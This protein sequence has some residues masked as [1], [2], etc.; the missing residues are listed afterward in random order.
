MTTPLFIERYLTKP[1]QTESAQGLAFINQLIAHHL[2]HFSFCSAN[3]LLKRDLSLDTEAV[4]QR[5]IEQRTGGYCFE[6]NKLFHTLLSEL[7]FTTRPLLARVLLNGN[8]DNGRT[9][10]VTLLELNGVQYLVDVGF[11]VQTPRMAIPLETHNFEYLSQQ[12]RLKKAQTHFRLELWQDDHWQALYRFDLSE[13]T[14]M[15]CDIGHFYTSQNPAS[16][17]Y[18]NLVISNLSQTQRN[19]LKNL[20]WRQYDDEL[21]NERVVNIES[22]QQLHQLLRQTFQLDFDEQ[23][24]QQLFDHQVQF[25]ASKESVKLD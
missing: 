1:L 9:H 2:E 25:L 4:Y 14:E 10:R 7:G 16:G 8:E 22:A 18:R 21:G 6:H 11:G 19:L 17:F 24:A 13:V 23:Q 20:E 5:L 12:F 15:D 3:V